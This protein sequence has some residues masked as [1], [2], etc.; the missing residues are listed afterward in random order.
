MPMKTITLVPGV[1][2]EKTYALNEAGVVVSEGIRYKNSMI[3]KLGGWDLYYPSPVSSTPCRDIHAFQGLKGQKF[4]GIGSLSELIVISCGILSNITPQTNTIDA[5]PNF[6]ISSG[7][8]VVTV[9]QSGSSAS[10]YDTVYFN[11]PIALP[12]TLLNGAYA[13]NSVINSS[14]FTILTSGVSSATIASSGILPTFAVTANSPIIDVVL[15]NNNFQKVIGLFYPFI[16]A[17]TV[18]G[19]TIQ[20]PYEVSAIIDSTHFQITANV[21]S[22]ATAGPTAMNGGNAELVY[23]K[24]QGPAPAGIAYGSGLYGTGLYGYG[25]PSAGGLGTPITATEWTLDN[26]GE[27]FLACP[28]VPITAGNPLG[29]GPI[30]TWSADSGFSNAQ[31]IATAPFFNLGIFVS[32]PQQI[33]MAWGSCQTSG[34]QDPLIVKWSNSG[35]YTNWNIL[36]TDAAGAFHIPTGSTLMGGAQGPLF[37]LVWTDIDAWVIQYVG[38]PL[39]FGFT[40]V[41][42]GC[43]IIGPHAYD[44]HS[45]TA[46]WCGLNNFFYF[47]PNGVQ[48]LPCTVWDYFFQQLDTVNQKKIRCASNSVFSEISWFFPIIGGTG[49]NSNYVK[50]HIEGSEFEWDFGVIGRTAWVDVTALG[51]PIGV[52]PSGNVLQHEMSPDAAGSPLIAYFETGWFSISDGNELSFIDWIL[53]DMQWATYATRAPQGNTSGTI[54]FTFFAVDYAGDVANQRQYGPYNVTQANQFITTRI[55]GRLM[56][57]RVESSDLGSFWRLG[58]VRMRYGVSGRR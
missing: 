14:T 5:T 19:L 55:R 36:T 33:L 27:V 37:A 58:R 20:G 8:D 46:Y 56:R 53:P 26:W 49:E 51:F 13:V 50:L 18:G 22:S 10:I 12:S 38:Q 32:M 29:G 6:S 15:E 43:G 11:T 31:V 52:D 24:T 40:R 44:V 17:T 35:D 57:F 4:V 42:T 1:D 28:Q 25:T 2:T 21:Q 45:S 3:Q 54:T 30:Y 48:V 23:Y 41:A 39:V 34:A 7:S 9:Q 16:A 47:G